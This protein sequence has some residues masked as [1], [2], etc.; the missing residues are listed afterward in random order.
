M[1]IMSDD[2]AV[3]RI[4]QEVAS[5]ARNWEGV[6]NILHEHADFYFAMKPRAREQLNEQIRDLMQERMS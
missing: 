3:R 2:E 1:A 4:L 6:H 5:S